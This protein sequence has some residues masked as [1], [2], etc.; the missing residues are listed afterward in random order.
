MRGK[1]LFIAGGLAGYVLGARAG[2]Q[3]YEQIKVA[4]NDLWNAKPV[5]RRVSEVREFALDALG[6]VPAALL[7][8]VK[9]AYSSAAENKRSKSEN[10]Q[11]DAATATLTVSGT[12]LNSSVPASTTSE[13][14]FGSD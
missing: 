12:T 13:P 6:D 14:A 10:Q 2:R 9:K 1:L 11:A 5:Q 4:A 8:T 3:R 7:N